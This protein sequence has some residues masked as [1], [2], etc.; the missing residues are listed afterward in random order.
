M[1]G[2]DSRDVLLRVH[3]LVL[4]ASLRDSRTRLHPIYSFRGLYDVQR[5]RCTTAHVSVILLRY[6][7]G[8]LRGLS[9]RLAPWGGWRS[10]TTRCRASSAR[11]RSLATGSSS[12]ATGRLS[13]VLSRCWHLGAAA[14]RS[15]LWLRALQFGPLA[16][17]MA[18]SDLLAPGADAARE[19]SASPDCR[20]ASITSCA[21]GC[22]RR[23]DHTDCALDQTSGIIYRRLH[24]RRYRS[25]IAVERRIASNSNVHKG[26]ARSQPRLLTM[27]SWG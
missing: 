16:V 17:G 18:D 9:A 7:A 22:G 1:R 2:A 11:S 15:P 12:S 10:P 6:R 26:G 21:E 27:S 23:R 14:H 5:T 20:R 3:R 19:S 25:P 8:W 24:P 13:A 4:P